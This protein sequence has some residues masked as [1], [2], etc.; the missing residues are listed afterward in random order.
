ML[1][2]TFM[3]YPRFMI[4][5]ICVLTAAVNLAAGGPIIGGGVESPR[6]V[7][8]THER[9]VFSTILK[10][11]KDGNVNLNSLATALDDPSLHSLAQMLSNA[12]LTQLAAAM[13]PPVNL[14]NLARALSDSNLDL[15][16]LLARFGEPRHFSGFNPMGKGDDG[17]LGMMREWAHK[18]GDKLPSLST[19]APTP[20]AAP[21]A[22]TELTKDEAAA[23]QKLEN[24]EKLAIATRQPEAPTKSGG[25]SDGSHYTIPPAFELHPT[26]ESPVDV[27]H[28]DDDADADGSLEIDYFNEAL[29]H[30]NLL[31]VVLGV[32]FGLS[33]CI[34]LTTRIA[35]ARNSRREERDFM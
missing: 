1:F 20:V 18:V 35:K 29:E 8:V 23:M 32:V 26:N 27:S 28:N 2:T 9:S 13:E 15:D 12:N 3:D 22:I 5:A 11:F 4:I 33:L 6:S 19:I 16:K 7:G 10:S 21:P 17:L 14:T 34:F 30:A 31:Y 25:E 24:D